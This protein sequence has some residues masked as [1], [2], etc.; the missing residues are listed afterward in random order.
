MASAQEPGSVSLYKVS[1]NGNKTR[2][3]KARVEQL[4]PA[5]GAPDG[6]AASVST[7]EKLLTVGSPTVLNN[8]DILQVA[9]TLDASDGIDVSDSIWSIPLATSSGTSVI[10]QADFANPAAADVTPAA[11]TETV[12]AGYKIT[13]GPARLSGKIYLDIQD[14]TA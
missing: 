4:A 10:S 8:D 3:L 7:P 12:I 14:D 5:G 13:E 11:S 1:P 2:L 6:A 9:V